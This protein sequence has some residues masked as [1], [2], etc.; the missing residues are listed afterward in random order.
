MIL[1]DM[2]KELALAAKNLYAKGLVLPGEGN[3]S[4]RVPGEDVMIIT[5]TMN[6]YADLTAEDMAVVTLDGVSDETRSGSRGPSSEYRMHAAVLRQ[7]P[8]AMA[9]VHAHPPET[10]AHAVLGLEIPLVVEEM[11]IL[12]GGPVPCAPYRRTGTEDLVHA[13]LTSLGRGNAVMLA[14]HGLLTCGRTL[15]EAVDAVLVVEK[16][17]GIHRRARVLA[18]GRPLPAVPCADADVLAARFREKFSTD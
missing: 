14:N 10:S 15:T 11:A 6:R 18:D 8:R 17:A 7:R 12:L 5:P 3:L 16:L 4:M 13:V 2:K 1:D 9:V